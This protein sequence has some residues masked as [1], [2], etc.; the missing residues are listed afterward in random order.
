MQE[1]LQE[2]D[3]SEGNIKKYLT[4]YSCFI[5]CALEKSHIVSVAASF[6]FFTVVVIIHSFRFSGKSFVVSL[7]FSR[8]RMMKFSW[9]SW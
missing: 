6:I 9:T 3:I 7:L 2:E 1:L 8:Y 5:T 4:N